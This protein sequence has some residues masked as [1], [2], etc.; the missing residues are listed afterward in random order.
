MVES[1]HCACSPQNTP[2]SCCSTRW[3]FW[4]WVL[5]ETLA[6]QLLAFN[7]HNNVFQRQKRNAPTTTCW[8]EHI[9]KWM[10]RRVCRSFFGSRWPPKKRVRA[11]DSVFISSP[12]RLCRVR[13]YARIHTAKSQRLPAARRN[14]S[15]QHYV[16]NDNH[17]ASITMSKLLQ[18]NVAIGCMK[19]FLM[20]FNIAFWVSGMM[21]LMMIM[22]G[23]T[24]VVLLTK[25]EM[26]NRKHNQTYRQINAPPWSDDDDGDGAW[27]IDMPPH[28][29]PHLVY[30]D[31]RQYALQCTAVLCL[32][33]A[34]ISIPKW[35]PPAL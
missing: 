3:V 25:W 15:R 8:H 14:S 33:R 29:S 13:P 2:T 23:K 11:R 34:K 5:W 30:I 12:S 4:V 18:T 31:L 35:L 32:C 28:L 20:I 1:M 27:K 16:W 21:V 10:R 24:R 6:P 9:D 19:S 7:G 17:T 22:N 26:R